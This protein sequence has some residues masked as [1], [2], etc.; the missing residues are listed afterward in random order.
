MRRLFTVVALLCATTISLTAQYRPTWEAHFEATDRNTENNLV[1][2]VS[3]SIDGVRCDSA[4]EI[5]VFINDVCRLTVPFSSTPDLYAKHGFYARMVI[6]GETGETIRFRL[7]DHR[8]KVEVEAEDCPQ[9]ITFVADVQ[10]GSFNTGL[11]ELTFERSTTHR[12]TLVLND[13]ID[14]P[15][16]GKQYGITSEGIACEYTREVFLD[17]RY[18]SVVLPFDADITD[19]VALGF[20]FEKFERIVGNTIQFVEL[21]E[22]EPLRAGIPYIFRYTGITSSDHMTI[23]FSCMQQ[24]VSDAISK[25][26]EWTGTFVTM[27]G[28]DIEG[29]YLLNLHGDRIQEVENETLL[30]P[31]Q[32]YFNLPKGSNATTYSVEHGN[33]STQINISDIGVY[34]SDTFHDLQG[35]KITTPTCGIYIKNGRNVIIK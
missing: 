3:G 15:F 20:T 4:F 32:A 31:Y 27:K 26:S 12:T 29:K 30:A 35:R 23:A 6:K 13:D 2:T 16:T 9:E 21:D 22:D 28:S 11:Y 33:L 18:E 5:G 17:G 24:Q 19:I 7:Y 1:M 25:I 34:S 8:N 14:L 10:Y